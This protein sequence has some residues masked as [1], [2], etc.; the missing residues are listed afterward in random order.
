[1]NFRLPH[2]ELRSHQDQGQEYT[3]ISHPFQVAMRIQLIEW[4]EGLM[5]S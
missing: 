1:M 3:A 5:R 2:S 4:H